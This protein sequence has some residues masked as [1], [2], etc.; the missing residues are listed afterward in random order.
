MMLG[1]T[2]W[3]CDFGLRLGKV[4]Q[5]EMWL[6]LEKCSFL[7]GRIVVALFEPANS[8]ISY[9][10]TSEQVLEHRESQE[11][12]TTGE[13]WTRYSRHAVVG[14]MFLLNRRVFRLSV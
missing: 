13:H 6:R 14:K 11:N 4:L 10:D 1:F 3:L 8:F 5:K 7:K 2:V 9:Q 12:R